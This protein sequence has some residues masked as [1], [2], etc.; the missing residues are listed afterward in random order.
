MKVHCDHHEI[1][2]QEGLLLFGVKYGTKTHKRFL[3]RHTKRLN[4]ILHKCWE[5]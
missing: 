3:F 4:S 2:A 1:M 5:K